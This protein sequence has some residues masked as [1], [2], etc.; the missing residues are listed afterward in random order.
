MMNGAT[1]GHPVHPAKTVAIECLLLLLLLLDIIIEP[2]G[3]HERTNNV[4]IAVSAAGSVPPSQDNELH[5]QD[6]DE[7]RRKYDT[8][9]EARELDAGSEAYGTASSTSSSISTTPTAMPQPANVSSDYS[10]DGDIPLCNRDYF[11]L[12]KDNMTQIIVLG[13]CATVYALLLMCLYKQRI[14]EIYLFQVSYV[15]MVTLLVLDVCFSFTTS[16]K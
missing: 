3:D 11:T 2:A 14:N 5:R 13:V 15:I 16:A 4:D 10:E 6:N 12:L 8:A 1:P 9:A 7:R